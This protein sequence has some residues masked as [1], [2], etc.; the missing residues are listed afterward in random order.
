MKHKD[1][2]PANASYSFYRKEFLLSFVVVVRALAQHGSLE[3]KGNAPPEPTLPEVF[4]DS[5]VT[6]CRIRLFPCQANIL[7]TTSSS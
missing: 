2:P 1:P 7:I 4:A 6:V 5:G 3:L